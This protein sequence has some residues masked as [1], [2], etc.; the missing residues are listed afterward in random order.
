MMSAMNRKV[1][2]TCALTG[3]GDTTGRSEHVP[4]TPEQI[5]QS[6]ID[7]AR[8]G[9]FARWR[10]RRTSAGSWSSRSTRASA[11]ARSSRRRRRA[12]S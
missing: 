7:A 8:A 6:G 9:A 10:M 11:P 5:A 12:T 1:I 4:I 2:V 3:A